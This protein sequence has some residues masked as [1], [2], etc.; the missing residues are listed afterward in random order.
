MNSASKTKFIVQSSAACMPSSCWGRYRRVAVLEVQE[1]VDRVK[2]ISPRALGV[3]R[4][5]RTWEKRSVG[6]TE[7]CAYRRAL[8]EA[9]KLAASL[10]AEVQS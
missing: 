8:Q 1:G 4:V 3:V 5:V 10:A 6:S 9:Q 7:R 2:M